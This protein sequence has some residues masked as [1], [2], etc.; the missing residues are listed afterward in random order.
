MNRSILFGTF[1]IFLFTVRVNG[2]DMNNHQE[3][4]NQYLPS[5]GEALD[6]K[7]PKSFIDN[8]KTYVGKFHIVLLHFPIVTLVLLF[9][10]EFFLFKNDFLSHQG[11]R[12]FML[13]F[14][15]LFG[16]LTVSAGWFHAGDWS[17]PEELISVLTW[18]SRAAYLTLFLSILSLFMAL[19][20]NK[21]PSMKK[22]YKMTLA[23][24]LGSVLLTAFWG[25]KITFGTDY[26]NWG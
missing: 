3:I 4:L 12:I 15:S 22:S 23:F 10:M 19:S 21:W 6:S 25:G 5:E 9:A 20:I 18:H 11:T 2:E 14:N 13:S 24:A 16:V 7:P 17:L 26:L 8:F 1:I